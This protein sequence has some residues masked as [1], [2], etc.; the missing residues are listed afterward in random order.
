MKQFVID[1]K[2]GAPPVT[3]YFALLS[4]ATKETGNGKPYL[5]IEL[6]DRTGSVRCRMWDR[7]SI[8]PEA[9]DIVQIVASVDEYPP[10]SGKPQFKI[11]KIRRAKEA[12]YDV[13]DML[14][15]SERPGIEMLG[16]L[17]VLIKTHTPKP[18][19]DVLTSI[20]ESF[21]PKICVAP[22][23]KS[24][25]HAYVGGLVEHMLGISRTAIAL[26]GVYPELD[27]PVLLAGAVLHDIGKLQELSPS[28][29]FKYTVHGKLYGHIALGF[30]FAYQILA[31][32]ELPAEFCDHVLHLVASH[33]GEIEHGAAA[34]PVTREAIIFHEID[35]IDS[36]MGAIRAAYKMPV[37]DDG[38]TAFVPMFKTGLLLKGKPECPTQTQPQPQT[39]PP[40]PPETASSP[41]PSP[42]PLPPPEEAR[43]APMS[44]PTPSLFGPTA[45]SYPD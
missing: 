42:A 28:L 18:I 32:C 45:K 19:A 40:A 13:A 9:G 5:D 20:L 4:K 39:Q 27:L 26:A 10:G 14:P 34:I 3:E 8:L 22:A 33:H 43:A 12:E 11:S 25:H 44:F 30:E 31:S 15:S 1:I 21:G 7:E 29:G 38:F 16:E 35:M 41:S 24:Y 37:D 17:S 36:R 6:G 23:A 2:P